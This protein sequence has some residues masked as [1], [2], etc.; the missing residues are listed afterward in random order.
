MK[1][2]LLPYLACPSCYGDLDAYPKNTE[3]NDEIMNGFLRCNSCDKR[4][5]VLHGIPRF[6]SAQNDDTHATTMQTKRVYNFTWRHFGLHEITDNWQ[7]DSYNYL[8]HLPSSLLTGKEKVGLEAGCGSGADLLKL[9]SGGP[10]IIGVDL[11]EGVETAYQVTKHLDNVSIVQ[12][13]IYNLPFKPDTFDFIYSLGVLHH[14]PDTARGFKHLSDVIKTGC[15][16]IT[17][18]YE[19]LADRSKIERALLRVST[20]VRQITMRLPAAF[21]NFA[22]RIAVPLVWLFL[23]L[24]ARLIRRILPAVFIRIPFRHTLNW[25]TLRSDLF[26][27][28]APP[29]ENRYDHEGVLNLYEHA[30]FTEV[31]IRKYR[32]WVSWGF[33][34]KNGGRKNNK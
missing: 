30:G 23:S 7:K 29:V 14:L 11:S 22:C 13:D 21:L 24:P 6:P 2:R 25:K 10:T 19:D 34:Q 27:R 28:L 26:D 3:D 33:A 1:I 5:P 8:Q 32:G 20:G 9:S 31:K 12:A 17:Y 15:P 16:L 18:L 4:Y